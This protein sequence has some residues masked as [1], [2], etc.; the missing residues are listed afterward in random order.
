VINTTAG[1]KEISDSYAI[2]R[3]ALTRGLSY[4]TTMEAA[5]MG[6]GAL[7]AQAGGERS[8][9]PIQDWLHR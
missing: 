2:R 1:K 4:F 7:E 6:V 9:R 3:E 8:Y 5:K